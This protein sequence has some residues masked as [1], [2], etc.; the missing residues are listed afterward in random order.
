[1]EKLKDKKISLKLLYEVATVFKNAECNS[2]QHSLSTEDVQ[3]ALD[4]RGTSYCYRYIYNAVR[5]LFKQGYLK[6]G[7]NVGNFKGYY[8]TA[9]GYRFISNIERKETEG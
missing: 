9:D 1:M 3:K 6:Q 4:E 7:F 2:I 5:D 8:I